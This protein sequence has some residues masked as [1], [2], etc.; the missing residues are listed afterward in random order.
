MHYRRASYKKLYLQAVH[1]FCFYT[2]LEYDTSFYTN[3]S[4]TNPLSLKTVHSVWATVRPTAAAPHFS[5]RIYVAKWW[6]IPST[7]QLLFITCQNKTWP[8]RDRGQFQQHDECLLTHGVARE[9]FEIEFRGVLRLADRQQS[10]PATERNH[11]T[12]LSVTNNKR[13]SRRHE[14]TGSTHYIKI[15]ETAHTVWGKP[16][17]YNVCSFEATMTLESNVIVASQN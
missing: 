6:P 14:S 13:Y 1:Y 5:A 16:G 11:R 10:S 9:T 7:A 3:D 4:P 12:H 2:L 15:Y 17:I 8:R